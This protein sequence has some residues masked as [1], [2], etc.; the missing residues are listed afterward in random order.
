MKKTILIIV[1]VALNAIFLFLFVFLQS[2]NSSDDTSNDNEKNE[3]QNFDDAENNN[4]ENQ[5][6][7][8]EVHYYPDGSIKKLIVKNQSNNIRIIV[9]YYL[10]GQIESQG[11]MKLA[12]S[13]NEM[14][15]DQW[16]W[17]NVDGTIRQ[18]AFYD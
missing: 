2:D 4:K 15:H 5:N 16:I 14:L 9:T 12:K 11:K 17:F 8:E 3:E 1:S 6:F 10:N 13:G 18:E 7:K